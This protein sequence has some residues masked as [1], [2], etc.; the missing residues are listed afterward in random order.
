[1]ESFGGGDIVRLLRSKVEAVSGETTY[2]LWL[3]A[4]D[5][6]LQH[7]LI[8]K[9]RGLVTGSA[10]RVPRAHKIRILAEVLRGLAK[11]EKAGWVHGD[12]TPSNVLVF[13]ECFSPEGCHAKLADFGSAFSVDASAT[14]Y[15]YDGVSS[16]HYRSPEAWHGRGDLSKMDVWSAGMVAFELFVGRLPRALRD[17]SQEEQGQLG[18][19][20]ME[21]VLSDE[22]IVSDPGFVELQQED[23][24]LAKLLHGMLT[25]SVERRL[26]AK[27]AYDWMRSIAKRHGVAVPE[28]QEHR[29]AFAAG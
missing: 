6:D 2:R 13:G 25:G 4:A 14:D 23:P 17:P 28:Q 12:V 10:V 29:E 16:P 18:A 22:E 24:Q 27:A 8:A 11:L 21:R 15:H 3:E 7:G 19:V 9:E 5:T 1:L 26:S 20:D